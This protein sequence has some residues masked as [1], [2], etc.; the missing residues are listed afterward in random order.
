MRPNVKQE[1]KLTPVSNLEFADPPLLRVV[2]PI[3]FGTTVA[4][5][6]VGYVSHLEV[7]SAPP[8]A[9]FSMLLI[10]IFGAR[11]A[12][13]RSSAHKLA[14]FL[15]GVL[16]SILNL[17]ILASLEPTPLQATGFTILG[18]VLG[19]VGGLLARGTPLPFDST[20]AFARIAAAATFLLVIIGGIV[21]SY[22][23]GLAVPDWPTSFE[24]NMFLLPLTQMVS[25]SA[26][27]YEHA[28]RLF[29]ALVGLTTLAMALYLWLVE[30][31]RWVKWFGLLLLILV[32]CQG[33][34]GGFRVELA[35]SATETETGWSRVL[36]VAHGV[37]GQLFFALVVSMAAFVSRTW[38]AGS[39]FSVSS[40][41][42]ERK[43]VFLLI[44]TAIG[45]LLLGALVRHLSRD[46]WLV[47]HILGAVV[48]GGI[49]VLAS[50]RGT[51][52]YAQCP[53]VRLSSILLLFLVI[54]QW[55]LGFFALA[56]GGS[57]TVLKA[58]VETSHQATGALILAVATLHFLWVW[59][60]L[61]PPE[62][63]GDTASSPRP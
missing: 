40:S 59:R 4:M 30:P 43:L 22:D 58:L 47:P 18:G 15:T 54:T 50:V 24:A 20:G 14:G 27:Y 60:C 38:K 25:E 39:R 57:G 7:F 29:G 17:L 19:L 36:R 44:S 23:A 48:V 52:L 12:A 10:Q 55:L 46:T 11:F 32:I 6:W 26:V 42:F 37:T 62:H 16:T 1:S 3:S 63:G 31:R 53:P 34:M 2:V 51:S 33:V 28:H 41:C 21:T 49:A 45:Q 5:W 56:V 61:D 35:D 13:L 8:V 9:L